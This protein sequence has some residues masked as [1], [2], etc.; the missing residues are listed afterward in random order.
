MQKR[1]VHS[2]LLLAVIAFLFLAGNLSAQKTVAAFRAAFDQAVATD[3]FTRQAQLVDN[4]KKLAFETFFVYERLWA[5]AKV[6]NN[7]EYADQQML[8]ME[9]LASTFRSKHSDK[10]LSTRR[11][12]VNALP[13]DKLK[14]YIEARDEDQAGFEAYGNGAAD[15]NDESMASA[16]EHYTKS[17]RIYLKIGDNYLAAQ[18]SAFVGSCWLKSG[19]YFNSAYWYET[20]LKP[21]QAGKLMA[22][23]TFVNE[24][25]R[26]MREKR[27]VE[28]PEFIDPSLDIKAAKIAYDKKLDNRNKIDTTGAAGSDKK[29]KKGGKTPVRDLGTLVSPTSEAEFT[30]ETDEGFKEKSLPIFT[31]IKLPYYNFGACR[32]NNPMKAPFY[33]YIRLQKDAEP[34]DTGRFLPGSEMEYD[35][36]IHYKGKNDKKAKAIKVKANKFAKVKKKVVYPDNS[37]RTVTNMLMDWDAESLKLFGET[38][39]SADAAKGKTLVW[40]GATGVTGKIRGHDVTLIDCNGNGVFRDTGVDAVMVGKGK[41]ARIEPLG[42]YILLED[43]GGLFPFDIKVNDRRGNLVRTRPFKGSLAPVIVNYKTKSGARPDYLIVKGDG[44]D[45]ES[46]FDVAKAFDKPI[47]IPPGRYFVHLGYFTFGKGKKQKHILIGRGRSG[48]LEAKSGQINT[49]N[50]GGAGEKGFWMIGKFEAGDKPGEVIVKGK[51]ILVFGNH[52][53]S[54]FNFYAERITPSVV[55]RKNDGNGPVMGKKQ[56][57]I[58]TSG[59]MIDLWFPTNIKIKNTG[60]HKRVGQLTCEHKILGHIES[61]WIRIE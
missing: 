9:Y 37:T 59:Q 18:R 31:K 15:G 32:P 30:W 1:I 40:Y 46:Y 4:D 2:G 14:A 57:K 17:S 36:K 5:D 61:D 43:Q 12:R 7:A 16:I 47:W 29:S 19:R 3:D 11:I 10:F 8:N 42:K 33:Q 51:D 28:F 56:M 25:L 45:A 20:A 38:Y 49:W 27:Q 21:A 22:R 6:K 54:Y 48:V 34:V 35:G 44:E 53:E 24:A 26:K 23:F 41:N 39:T 50:L 52:G 58:A 55:I 13:V 60:S